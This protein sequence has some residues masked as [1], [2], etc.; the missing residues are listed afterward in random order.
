MNVPGRPVG[1]GIGVTVGAGE[2]CVLWGAVLGAGVDAS[3][4]VA[5]ALEQP[6]TAIVRPSPSH[7]PAHLPDAAI[8]R[9][10]L[11]LRRVYRPWEA[12]LITSLSVF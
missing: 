4:V 3:G 9:V 12:A 1:L 6:T 7:R 5:T 10:R 2:S 11:W 8:P